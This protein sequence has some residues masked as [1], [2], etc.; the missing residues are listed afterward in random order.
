MCRCC[1]HSWSPGK[2]LAGVT[3]HASHCRCGHPVVPQLPLA[4]NETQLVRFAPPVQDQVPVLQMGGLVGW[5]NWMFFFSPALGFEP[6][7]SSVLWVVSPR[8]YWSNHQGTHT[9][10]QHNTHM[11]SN[12]I[13]T[14]SKQGI[15]LVGGPNVDRVGHG[16]NVAGCAMSK[17][18]GV[19]KKAT[20]IAINIV[21]NGRPVT[22]FVLV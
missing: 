10:T 9:H 7:S 18:Y 22:S 17:T 12:I 14:F 19:A 8:L 2:E 6:V 16:T 4:D 1:E 20:A 5:S 21:R 3:N 15:N 11:H 13:V